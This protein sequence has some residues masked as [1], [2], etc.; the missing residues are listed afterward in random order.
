MPKSTTVELE[1]E[2][3]SKAIPLKEV[4]KIKRGFTTGANE[5][6]Y[7]TEEQIKKKGIEKEFWMHKDESGKWV[8]NYLI[9]SPREC[10]SLKVDRNN[11][12][13]RVLMINKEKSKL[14]N[15]KILNHINRGERQELN[16]R[17]TCD[18]RTSWYNLGDWEFLSK[19]YTF[20]VNKE[21]ELNNK[22]VK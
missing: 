18:S 13:F 10:L 4:A 12:K 16:K 17:P 5:F 22:K 7:L 6:F 3:N 19:I 1:D 2:F 11:L 15:K 8:P 9:K 14:K 20:I 21:K